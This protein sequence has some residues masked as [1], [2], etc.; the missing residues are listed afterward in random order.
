MFWPLEVSLTTAREK[1]K[2]GEESNGNNNNKKAVINASCGSMPPVVFSSEEEK[3]RLCLNRV[4]PLKLPQPERLAAC[5]ES[6]VR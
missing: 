5:K 1:I 2:K 3:S 6:S 4:K